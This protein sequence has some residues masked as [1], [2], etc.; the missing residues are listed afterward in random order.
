MPNEAGST[1]APYASAAH[2]S[3]AC[4][5]V[6]TM[7]EKH[8]CPTTFPTLLRGLRRTYPNLTLAECLAFAHRGFN[9]VEGYDP[10]YGISNS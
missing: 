6:R 3:L 5:F 2:K 10:E 4:L 9:V 8:K 7:L 1:W